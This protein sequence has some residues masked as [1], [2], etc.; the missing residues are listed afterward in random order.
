MV[1]D[2]L[3]VARISLLKSQSV[4]TRSRRSFV[5]GINEVLG[6]I[7]SNNFGPQ[8]GYRKRCR[9]I[10]AAEVQNAQRSLYPERLN[11]CFS[12]LT[13]ESCDLGKVAF[14]PQSFVWIHDGS[15]I[16]STRACVLLLAVRRG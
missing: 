9:A 2:P 7:D 15:L 13:H 4:E 3:Q 16:S 11:D 10:S 12:R 1:V 14:L 8:K 5:P 6:Y